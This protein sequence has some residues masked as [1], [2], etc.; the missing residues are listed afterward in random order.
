MYWITSLQNT[1]WEHLAVVFFGG[2]FVLHIYQREVPNIFLFIRN[3]NL[4]PLW[5]VFLGTGMAIVV[6]KCF[7]LHCTW[8]N[9]P[10]LPYPQN[11]NPEK[12]RTSKKWCSPSPSRSAS[13]V[14]CTKCKWSLQMFKRYGNCRFKIAIM[15]FSVLS[16]LSHVSGAQTS[17][18]WLYPIP[19]SFVKSIQSSFS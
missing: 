4:S 1:T 9:T 5:P 16:Y 19:G 14:K 2:F 13:L 7:S 15:D 6:L 10:S 3:V 8:G 18:V 11:E 12:K 17:H